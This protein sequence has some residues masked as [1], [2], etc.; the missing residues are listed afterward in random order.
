MVHK[1][2]DS[3]IKYNKTNHNANALSIS[4]RNSYTE[5]QLIHTFLDN[6][7]QGGKYS[8]HIEIC[9]T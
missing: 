5:D 4:V 6:F 1:G 9:Q 8:A 2:G 3:P 7:Q